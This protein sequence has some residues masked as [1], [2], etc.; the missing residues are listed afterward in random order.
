M[1]LQKTLLFLAGA[2]AL[3]VA[4][5]RARSQ[6]SALAHYTISETAAA[7]HAQQSMDAARWAAANRCRS[8]GGKPVDPAS[9]ELYGAILVNDKATY[10]TRA[11]TT[12]A[13]KR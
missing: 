11:E 8:F 13:L 4:A 10:L 5:D 2:A 6:T 3:T 9:T 7:E 12:C 1:S